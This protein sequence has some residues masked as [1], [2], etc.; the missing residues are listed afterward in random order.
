V[1]VENGI[2]ETL[3]DARNRR[4]LGLEEVEAATKIR[5]RFLRAME[6][7]EWEALPGSAYTRAF[8]RTYA[9]YLGLD[10]ERIADDYRSAAEQPGV[11][12]PPRIEPASG[13]PKRRPRVPGRLVGA[14]VFAILIAA[15]IAIGLISGGGHKSE[16][17]GRAGGGAADRASRAKGASPAPRPGVAVRLA[18]T[19]EVWVCMLD[20]TGKP[21][22][23]GEILEPGTEVG[24]FRAQGFKAAF[25]NGDFELTINGERADTPPSSSPVGYE[26]DAAGRLTP[27]EEGERPEC[28]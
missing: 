5:V 10:G 7:E 23:D 21:V 17:A 20:A 8:L 6:N 2:G 13:G 9:S 12:R 4:K 22:I 16:K 28:A 18:A 25:G 27:L 19:A 15:V 1:S 24:P 14:L 3:R 11:P 26:I